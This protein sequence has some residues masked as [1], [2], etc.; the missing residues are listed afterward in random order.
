[1]G[2]E[3]REK[4]RQ[5]RCVAACVSPLCLHVFYAGYSIFY[6]QFYTTDYTDAQYCMQLGHLIYSFWLKKHIL[7]CVSLPPYAAADAR[8]VQ[9][10]QNRKVS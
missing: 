7:G 4:R 2:Q 6:P 5:F 3:V 1:M 8:A 9:R 10:N